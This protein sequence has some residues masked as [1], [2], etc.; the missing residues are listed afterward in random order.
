MKSK[1]KLVSH[2]KPGVSEYSTIGP[3]SFGSPEMGIYRLLPL[4]STVSCSFSVRDG[5][6]VLRDVFF[7]VCHRIGRGLNYSIEV[8]KEPLIGW[9]KLDT[10]GQL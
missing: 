6:F 10:S 8:H 4:T 1:P 5:P 9:Y 7:G 2:K 3:R